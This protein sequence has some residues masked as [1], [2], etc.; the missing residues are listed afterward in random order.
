VGLTR[1]GASTPQRATMEDPI[2][3]YLM[4]SSGEGSFG[5]PSPKRRSMWASFAPATTTTQKENAP[6]TMR[7]PL[8]MVVP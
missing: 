6:A 3:E 4:A 5:H 1:S 7:F 8:W 2:E